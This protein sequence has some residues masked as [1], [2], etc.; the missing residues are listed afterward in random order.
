MSNTPLHIFDAMGSKSWHKI[1]EG[2]HSAPTNI[3]FDPLDKKS[4]NYQTINW[5]L[6]CAMWYMTTST[7]CS[8]TCHIYLPLAHRLQVSHNPRIGWQNKWQ[9][10]RSGT[11]WP[12][13]YTQQ[14]KIIMPVCVRIR[15]ARAFWSCSQFEQRDSSRKTAYGSLWKWTQL[16]R[17]S[18][19]TLTGQ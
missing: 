16:E 11:S 14:Q 19:S 6:H 17:M 5:L 10:W 18:N 4:L 2:N 13:F 3:W 7:R 12:T 15:V 1:N 9:N 8:S